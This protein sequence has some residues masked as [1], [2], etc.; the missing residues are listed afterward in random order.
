MSFKNHTMLTRLRVK[1]YR[2]LADIDIEFAPL[3]VLVGMNGAGKSNVVDVLRFVRDAVGR[4]LDSAILDR[5][6]MNALRRWSAKGAPYD[7]QVQLEINNPD[8]SGEYG[9]TLGSK[10][11]DEYR[12]K[13]EKI[14]ITIN[15]NEKQDSRHFSFEFRN[16]KVNKISG[17]AKHYG[18]ALKS[19][20]TS[21]ALSSMMFSPYHRFHEFFKTFGFYTIFPDIIRKPQNPANPS[22]LNERGENLAS[23]LRDLKKR[24]RPETLE[25]LKALGKVVEDVNDYSVQQ[26]GGYLVTKLH[27]VSP[28]GKNHSPTFPLAQESDGT[29]R[30]LGILTALYQVPPRSLIAIEEP[31]L[32][33]HPGALAVLCDVL[34]EA[35]LQSQVLITTHSPELISHFPADMLRVVEKVNGSTKVGIIKENQRKAIRD[36]LFLAGEIMTMEGLQREPSLSEQE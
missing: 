12:V 32:T 18:Y 10:Q 17:D 27:H 13:G 16:G 31:E 21:L 34:M 26:I 15:S 22:P 19:S 36:K 14:C 29:L 33:I 20:P 35:S 3:T 1:N 30:M 7:V 6:G 23:L 11:R 9:F 28:G 5:N 24:K 8:W 25:M 4:G 2:S